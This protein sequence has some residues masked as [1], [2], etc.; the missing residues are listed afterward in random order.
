[1]SIIGGPAF[2]SL[3]FH[4][5]TLPPPFVRG[6]GPASYPRRRKNTAVRRSELPVHPAH[7]FVVLGEVIDVP[8]IQ[9][10]CRGV[11]DVLA[12]EDPI[13]LHDPF[14]ALCC[15]RSLS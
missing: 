9:I 11:R 15:G 6:P 12:R 4:T 10:Y 13:E 8:L 1:M 7:L 3:S 5:R 14:H 2:A